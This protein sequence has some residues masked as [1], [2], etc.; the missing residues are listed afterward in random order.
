MLLPLAFL[1]S[2]RRKAKVVYD[3][4]EFH[5]QYAAED[6]PLWQRWLVPLLR[7]VESYIVSRVAGVLTVDSY[8]G[9][10]A[11]RYR[12]L[13]P[14]TE[15]LYNVPVRGEERPRASE[16][17]RA[18]YEGRL[19]VVYIGG[20]SE[21]KGALRAVEVAE[22]VVLDVPSG[23]FLFIGKFHERLEERFWERVDDAGLRDHVEYVPWLPYDEM[24]EYLSIA[25]VGLAL[26]QPNERYRMVGKGNG[27]KMFTYMHVGVPIVGPDFGA[28]GEL[29][30]DENVGLVVDTTN[31]AEIA[32]AVTRLLHHP[33]EARAYGENGRR[34]IRE[35]YNW[36][37][38]TEKLLRVYSAMGERA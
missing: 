9:Q 4:Y 20:M 22:S 37:T 21:K 27:R 15:V 6:L 19:L 25:R 36:E 5:L 8:R 2:R 11:A 34:A 28:L 31:P 32:A 33:E 38:E 16:E 29:I 14:N 35:R 18:R 3:V 7:R 23:L 24:M 10:L 30:R 26:H 17:L 1:A 13:N 12:S